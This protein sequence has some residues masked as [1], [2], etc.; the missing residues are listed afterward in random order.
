MTPV[1]QLIVGLLAQADSVF[2]PLRDPKSSTWAATH[3]LRSGYA[4]RGLP[5]RG[6]GSKEAQ[7]DLA[8]AAAIDLVVRRKG[9]S[10]TVG[11]KLTRAGLDRAWRLV[12][13]D[14]ADAL[15]V[16]R[17]VDRLAPLGIW[18]RETRFS[19]G[20]GWGDGNEAELAEVAR[21]HRPALAAGW[22]E[23]N[24]DARRHVAYRTTKAGRA[25]LAAPAEATGPE[26]DAPSK[27]AGDIYA[28]VYAETIM[29]LDSI[30]PESVG[31]AKLELGELPLSCA[32]WA[33]AL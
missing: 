14:P 4:A 32:V 31:A 6:G 7:R 9:R 5:W 29:W 3:V 10:R 1:E 28:R 19:N 25:A 15:A 20:M 16:V 27:E 18:V 21:F 33:T 24:S 17:E 23:S 13:V 12:G 26:P 30:T 8:E 22:I 2:E 11:V